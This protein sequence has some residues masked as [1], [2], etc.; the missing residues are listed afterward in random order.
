MLCF[1]LLTGCSPFTVE[2]SK[3]SSKEIAEFVGYF[4]A[5]IFSFF[6]RI[7]T[8]KVPFPRT[9]DLIAKDFIDRLLNKNGKT[10]MGAKGVEEIK[11]HKF[12]QV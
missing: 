5:Q 12:F 9:M 2:G 8:K 6:S 4:P 10:R 11:T 1:E 3:N 7:L